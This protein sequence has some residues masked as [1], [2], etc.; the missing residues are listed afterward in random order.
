MNGVGSRPIDAGIAGQ[1]RFV[2]FAGPRR[3]LGNLMADKTDQ[4]SSTGTMDITDHVRTWKGFLTVIK[5]SLV[6]ILLIV[7][8][9][10]IF[11]VH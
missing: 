1:G 11:R 8:F 9:M 2:I 10:A 4:G 5:W 7:G 6:A 3:F